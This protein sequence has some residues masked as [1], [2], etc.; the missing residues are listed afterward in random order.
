MVLDEKK[1]DAE[2]FSKKIIEFNSQNF[3]ELSNKMRKSIHLK[4]AEKIVHEIK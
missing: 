1:F 3:S 4:S 2:D